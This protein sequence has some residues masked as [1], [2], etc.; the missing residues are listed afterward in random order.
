V[1]GIAAAGGDPARSGA[2]WI[3]SHL[4]SY[5]ARATSSARSSRS[6]PPVR[7]CTAS[8]E[9]EHDQSPNGS[10]SDQSNL[11]AFAILALR[12][13]SAPGRRRRSH[14]WLERQQNAD[15]GFSFAE[16]GSASD[17]DDTAGATRG[18]R[19]GRRAAGTITRAARYLRKRRTATAASP[20]S[21]VAPPNA[22][23]T[24]W[25]IQALLAARRDADR[26]A[27]PRTA[28]HASGAVDYSAGTSQTPV[29]V[30]AQAL[31]ALAGRP[32]PL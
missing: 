30:T 22:Q 18:A 8:S 20:S 4:G 6:A 3:E 16:R 28:D 5:R 13:A 25:A 27:L 24:A 14:A 9:L 26:R 10:F 12:R 2:A 32:L 7:R 19:R 15:G 31:A 1:I 11:T 29:W 21:P 23:S 17:V